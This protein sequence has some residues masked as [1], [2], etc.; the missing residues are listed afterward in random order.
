MRSPPIAITGMGLV[1][2]IGTSVQSTW[3]AAL[4]GESGVGRVESMEQDGLPVLIGGEVGELPAEDSMDS[5]QLR[6]VDRFVHL[7]VAAA[8]QAWRDSGLEGSPPERTGVSIGSGIG[9][10]SFI[11]R[12]S[13]VLMEKGYRR[14][15][16]FLLPGCI[17]NMASGMVSIDLGLK[18]PLIS[19]ATACATGA[20]SIGLAARMIAYGDADRML[21]G[22]AESSLDS[23]SICAFA[24]SRTLSRNN[25][26]PL[27]ASRP[28]DKDRDGF[29]MGEGAGVIVLERAEDAKAR[30]ATIYGYIKGFGMSSD[31]SH[32][33][34][35]DPE[36]DG[37]AR[38]IE[39]SLKDA[40]L[41]PADIQHI[42]AHATST[43]LGD[44]AEA[45]AIHRVFGANAPPVTATK[46][47]TG[48]LLGSAGA[49]ESI[50]TLQSLREQ[51]IHPTINLENQ[52]EQVDLNI[53]KDKAADCAMEYALCNSFG[54]GG[55]NCS[56][57]FSN[58]P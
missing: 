14:V 33:T 21:A 53:V 23:L 1:C 18:G 17:I 50:M 10:I 26:N 28:W 22:G 7:A 5:G 46:S 56:L 40:G 42:N 9:G 47:L 36:G 43:V 15:S 32:M 34:A 35:P 48:H 58:A 6:R 16:P 37:A 11:S 24:Q 30:G 13:K 41:S 20:H 2:P 3:Q 57:I 12:G 31:A 4:A 44:V 52:D 45:K 51:K 38:C 55:T 19:V 8:R 39:A 29:V 49:L 25:D 27:R 54:F